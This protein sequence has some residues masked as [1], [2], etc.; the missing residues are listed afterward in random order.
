MHLPGILFFNIYNNLRVLGTKFEVRV[1]LALD[2]TQLSYLLT[3]GTTPEKLPPPSDTAQPLPGMRLPDSFRKAFFHLPPEQ[4]SYTAVKAQTQRLN[5]TAHSVMTLYIKDDVDR[6]VQLL[7]YWEDNP[8]V[9][10]ELLGTDWV[11]LLI[12]DLREYLNNI[13]R[14]R[15]TPPDWTDPFNY[16]QY[17]DAKHCQVE[18]YLIQQLQAAATSKKVAA[19][20]ESHLQQGLAALPNPDSPAIRASFVLALMTGSAR[21]ST[22]WRIHQSQEP[23]RTKKE[24]QGISEAGSTGPP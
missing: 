3:F 24:G 6:A 15:R 19:G 7:A 20:Q 22:S 1:W 14:L 21:P 23:Q 16:G 2:K 18:N 10:H 11:K 13:G 8:P 17:M 5:L 12:W 4:L 9:A